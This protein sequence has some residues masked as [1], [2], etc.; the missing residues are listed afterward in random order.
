MNYLGACETDIIVIGTSIVSDYFTT[1]VRCRHC[2]SIFEGG[3]MSQQ[4]LIHLGYDI[5]KLQAMGTMQREAA[6]DLR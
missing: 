1:R 5:M 3:E 6:E 4:Q 2:R